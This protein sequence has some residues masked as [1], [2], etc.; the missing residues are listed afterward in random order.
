MLQ[1]KTDNHGTYWIELD[2]ECIHGCL[3][4]ESSLVWFKSYQKVWDSGYKFKTAEEEAE[5]ARSWEG[6]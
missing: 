6:L 4:K 3:T 2:G 5:L 1:I